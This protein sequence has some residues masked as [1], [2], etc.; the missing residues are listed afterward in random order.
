MGLCHRAGVEIPGVVHISLKSVM[1][2]AY[3][4]RFCSPRIIPR[5]QPQ[6]KAMTPPIGL[7]RYNKQL[8]CR[9]NWAYFDANRRS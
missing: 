6:P 4:L 3:V 7:G 1:D 5:N 9:Y 8:A 2:E